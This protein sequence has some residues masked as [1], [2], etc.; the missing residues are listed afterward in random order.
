VPRPDPALTL[1]RAKPTWGARKTRELLIRELKGL[2]RMLAR[3]KETSPDMPIILRRLAEGY[4]DLEAMAE[5]ERAAAQAAADDAAR[6]E[7]EAERSRRQR[8]PRGRDTVM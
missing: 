2:E 6:A 3:T 8:R 7:R 4:A 5:R 1:A